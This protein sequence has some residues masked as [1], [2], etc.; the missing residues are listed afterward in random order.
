VSPRRR[1]VICD[2][3]C[4][5]VSRRSL[6]GRGGVFLHALMGCMKVEGPAHAGGAMDICLRPYG[7]EGDHCFTRFGCS[8]SWAGV[9]GT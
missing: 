6:L 8:K 9:P 4:C 3:G 1:T 5:T 7:H 2:K